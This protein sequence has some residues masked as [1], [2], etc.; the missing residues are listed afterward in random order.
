MEN[1]QVYE[2]LPPKPFHPQSKIGSG[3]LAD[4][5]AYPNLAAYYGR[6]WRANFTTI[7]L[8]DSLAARVKIIESQPHE[9]IYQALRQIS[10]T[11]D[12]PVKVPWYGRL[13]LKLTS[14]SK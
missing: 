12:Q 11:P 3:I 8:L 1:E 10:L 7:D 14:W 5:L 6:D 13:L 4:E 9:D 2:F